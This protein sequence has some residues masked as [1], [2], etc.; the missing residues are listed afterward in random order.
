MTLDPCDRCEELLQ[1]FLDRTLTDAEWKEAE[2][3]LAGC[4]Y[5]RR[6]YRFEETPAPVRADELRRADAA[7]AHGQAHRAPRARRDRLEHVSAGLRRVDVARRTE[8]VARDESHRTVAQARRRGCR[9]SRR[10]R[11]RAD[12]R[13]PPSYDAATIPPARASRRARARPPRGARFGPVG[14]D[15]D[16]R[17][18]VVVESGEP[19]A[20]RRSR[21]ALPVRARDD[22][23]R[24]TLAGSRARARPRRR[25]SRRRTSLDSRVEHVREE[26]VLLRAAEPRRLAR[27]ED[28]RGDAP[29]QLDA[30]VTVFTTTGCDGG[31]SPTPSASI[32]STVSI[33][34]VTSPT[35]A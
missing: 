4:D 22:A 33:P 8:V 1:D 15:D 23:R 28:D 21:P 10:D 3:H 11:G 30:A 31:P 34:S 35:I 12:A 29:H 6:R 14:E 17:L 20:E 24:R 13:A 18:D 9:P 26:E 32:R 7:R 5:C 19:A 25:R 27:R 2:S 16:G